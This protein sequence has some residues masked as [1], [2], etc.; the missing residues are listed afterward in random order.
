[1]SA[2]SLAPAGAARTSTARTAHRMVIVAIT[3]LVGCTPSAERGSVRVGA[4]APPYQAMSLTGD[5]VSLE[6][7]RGKVVMLNIWAT[8][9]APCRDEIPVL[10]ALH[11][12]YGRDGLEIVGVSINARGEE[13]RIG[14]YARSIGM[15]YGIWHDPDDRISN[16]YRAIGVPA[17]YLIDRDGVLRWR[18]IGP[19]A[20]GDTSLL[21]A[22]AAAITSRQ[23]AQ[24]ASSG[25]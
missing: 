13:G 21:R 3:T 2:P 23:G 19:I 6:S 17:S 25:R 1:M 20:A 18:R 5:S 16:L 4:P 11:E 9:C 10:Q 15:T 14:E 8:W 22:L 7:L 24:G 12:Q